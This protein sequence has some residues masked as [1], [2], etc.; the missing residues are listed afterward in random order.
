[1]QGRSWMA[2][3]TLAAGLSPVA[4]R[5]QDRP[6][7]GVET[8]ATPRAAA[9]PVHT[10]TLE[11][12]IDGLGAKGCDVEVKPGHPACKFAPRAQHLNP[13]QSV[14]LVI[15]DVRSLSADRDCTFA[16]TVREPGQADRT[17]RRGLRLSNP[18]GPA[19]L[20]P[21]LLSTPPR[22][23]KAGDQAPPKR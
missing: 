18:G 12:A 10:V 13:R 21:C 14:K 3:L 6:L 22:V 2:A 4:T 16:I 15:D 8:K 23:A 19:Q 17:V 11:V 7:A 9:E 1:M 5:A 20:L